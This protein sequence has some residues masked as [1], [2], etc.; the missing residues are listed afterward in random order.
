VV[1]KNPSKLERAKAE[2]SQLKLRPQVKVQK[3]RFPG[4]S[5]S[6][7]TLGRKSKGS[8]RKQ[9]KVRKTAY[10]Q[11][12]KMLSKGRPKAVKLKLNEKSGRI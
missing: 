6:C 3:V 1:G 5:K 2:G 4:I 8:V 10:G 11:A 7:R 12:S 9:I